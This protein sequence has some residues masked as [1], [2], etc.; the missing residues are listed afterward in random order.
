MI[1]PAPVEQFPEVKAWAVRASA[2]PWIPGSPTEM[3]D[4]LFALLK[5][6]E[7]GGPLD[8]PFSWPFGGEVASI[9]DAL[10]ALGSSGLIVRDGAHPGGRLTEA[11]RNVLRSRDG[12]VLMATIHANIRFIGEALADLGDGL[13]H[14]ELNEV[15]K[16]YGLRW[17]S[18]DQVRRRVYWLRATGLVDYWSNGKAVPN[19]LGRA[20]LRGVTVVTPGELMVNPASS[21]LEVDLPDP[22]ELLAARLEA[23]GQD[24]L[25]VRNRVFGYIAGGTN[26]STIR[27]LVDA[28]SP[29]IARKDF[30]KLCVDHCVVAESSAEQTLLTFRALG[31]LEQVGPD[32]FA[33]TPL[34]LD[35]L[36]SEEDVDFIRF[37]H[38]NVALM[39][40]V[41]DA[42]GGGATAGEVTRSLADRYPRIGLS[43]DEIARRIAF[44]AE[45]GMIERVGLVVRQTPLGHALCSSLRLMGPEEDDRPGQLPEQESTGR[46]ERFRAL[47]AELVEASVDSANYRR[48]ERAIADAFAEL[49]LGVESGGGPSKT[50]VIVDV[51]QSPTRRVRVAVEAKTDGGGTVTEQDVKFEALEEHR[52]RHDAA[53]TV[54]IGPD[55]S[56]RLR[57]WANNKNVVM[58]TAHQLAGM[59]ARQA[60]TPLFPYELATLLVD[61]DRNALDSTWRMA[62]RRQSVVAHVLD[63]MWKS[64]NDPVEIDYSAGALGVRDIW[65]ESK[66]LLDLPMEKAEIEEA[67][68]FL[69]SPFIAGVAPHRSD[70]VATAPPSLVAA[71][72]RTLADLIDGG[73]KPTRA[74]EP[75]IEVPAPVQSET[76]GSDHGRKSVDAAAVRAWAVRQGRPISQRGR[77]S[78]QLIKEYLE[79]EGLE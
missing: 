19:D 72:L 32:S 6:V 41:L 74:D 23:L 35:V 57:Q 10:R 38:L 40:E 30:V 34:A 5:E 67:L 58:L 15:A 4:N 77:L 11:G 13:T 17:N 20:F 65:R 49:G 70:H 79:A 46:R 75:S 54:L 63:I 21:D 3:L 9:R 59:L 18:L 25:R 52:I 27:V 24:A 2:A 50:D 14:T 42:L 73:A 16:R 39:G 12:A 36:S 62:R 71:R 55:F 69:S 76:R 61:R 66:G 28:A 56:T 43:K 8:Q 26:L 48:F 78:E 64:G 37:L 53:V 29:R 1:G 45:A 47:G 22:P 31:L 44:L 51:W 7:A 68:A 60:E 33:A